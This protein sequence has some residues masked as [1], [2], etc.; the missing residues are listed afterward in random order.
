MSLSRDLMQILNLRCEDASSLTSKEL[1]EP[2][3]LAES[4]ALR[5]HVL[6][7]RSCRRLRRQLRFLRAAINH[8]STESDR[9]GAGLDTLSPQARER[10]ERAIVLAS[11][12]GPDPATLE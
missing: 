1:D 6:I 9:D 4:L 8:R 7:C 12:Q 2:L 11:S 5:G 3:R 10:I